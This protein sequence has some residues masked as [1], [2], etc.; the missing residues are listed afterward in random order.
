MKPQEKWHRLNNPKSLS[1]YGLS[2]NEEE[3][4]QFPEGRKVLFKV[5]SLI[6]SQKQMQ[7][8]I[9]KLSEAAT[10]IRDKIILSLFV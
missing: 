8:K 1:D 9:K 3:M 5:K 7:R 10:K 4:R 2:L 6:R